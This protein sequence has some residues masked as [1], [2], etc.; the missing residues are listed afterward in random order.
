LGVFNP[1]AG[2]NQLVDAEQNNRVVLWSDFSDVTDVV[3]VPEMLYFFATSVQ[4]RSMAATVEVVRYALGYWRSDQF[5]VE[6]GEAIGK[7]IEPEPPEERE[8][9]DERD[10]RAQGR[11][12]Q[13]VVGFDILNR[14]TAATNE[15]DPDDPVTPATIDFTTGVM[16]V[17]VVQVND[18]VTTPS[19][20]ARPYYDLLYTADGANIEHMPAKQ[21]CWPEKLRSARA[22]VRSEMRKTPK[23][24]RG[25]NQSSMGGRGMDGG[26]YQGMDRRTMQ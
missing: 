25:F 3:E 13:G 12:A 22:Y 18:W 2:T 20:R 11:T 21:E 1:V 7:E 6:R 4:E 24:F 10:N 14:Q 17:D 16:L 26:M 15:P 19:L 23:E 8:S 5:V 9:R